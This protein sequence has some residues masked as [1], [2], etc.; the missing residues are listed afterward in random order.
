MSCQ[1]YMRPKME[2]DSFAWKCDLNI[3]K[4]S[5]KCMPFITLPL[6]IIKTFS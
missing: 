2:Y 6:S 1:L 4:H 5:K 3:N